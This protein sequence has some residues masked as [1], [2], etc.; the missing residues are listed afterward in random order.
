MAKLPIRKEYSPIV[1]RVL[2]E[3]GPTALA[4]ELGV[5]PSAVT[6]WVRV[7]AEHVTTVAR[8]TGIPASELR[9]DLAALFQ[10]A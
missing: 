3:M 4:A 1:R 8:L 7:P 6:Q 5:G 10:A 2:E 9:P